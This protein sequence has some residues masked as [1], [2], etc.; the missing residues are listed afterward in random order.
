MFALPVF[1]CQDHVETEEQCTFTKCNQL[2]SLFP[3]L[4]NLSFHKQSKRLHH[5]N[6]INSESPRTPLSPFSTGATS[7]PS[8]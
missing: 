5:P 8:R 7:S 4:P 6:A 2:H 3:S 1:D